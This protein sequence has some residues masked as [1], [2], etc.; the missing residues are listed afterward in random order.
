MK[1][2]G[3]GLVTPVVCERCEDRRPEAPS[4]ASR[5]DQRWRGSGRPAP[6][7]AASTAAGARIVSRTIT[8]APMIPA[9]S[10][11]WLGT[12][13]S[14]PVARAATAVHHLADAGQQRL[15]GAGHVA[16]DHDDRP[17]SAC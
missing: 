4:V 1:P 16:T 5:A 7:S 6:T 3:W 14:R 9:S 12:I 13:R 17:G 8:A 15:A 10:P 2:T 11:S